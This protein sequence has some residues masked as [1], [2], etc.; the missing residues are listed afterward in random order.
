MEVKNQTSVTE[1]ILLGLTNELKLQ[2][3][4]FVLFLLFYL[5]TVAGNISI[6]ALIAVEPRLHTPMYL[7]L[8]NL[9]LSDFCYSSVIAPKMLVHFFSSRKV[10]SFNAC[11]AQTYF[12]G[13]FASIEGYMLAAMAYDRYA[14]ICHPLLYQVI[15]SRKVCIQLVATVYLGALL[16]AAVYTGSTFH[17]S[18]CGPNTINHFFCDMIPLLKLSCSDTFVGKTLIFVVGFI[19]GFTSLLIMIIS[20]VYIMAAIL[21]MRT[22]EGRPKAFSTCGSHLTVVFLF[23]GT[24]LFMY[25]RL[26]S[27]D[28][29]MQDKAV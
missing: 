11:A 1:F 5:V 18:F 28:S 21:R 26:P 6:V 3:P 8:S 17:N 14:A 24:A 10:I 13:V 15:I 9:S 12:F 19:F 16:T 29:V 7:L 23:Y 2:I 20:Y 4:L 27:S 25:L 22:N